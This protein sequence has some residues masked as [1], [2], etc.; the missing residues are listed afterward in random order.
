MVALG[1]SRDFKFQ[2]S[3]PNWEF[4]KCLTFEISEIISNPRQVQLRTILW[5]F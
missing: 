3:N 4:L 5:F 1:I 2:I